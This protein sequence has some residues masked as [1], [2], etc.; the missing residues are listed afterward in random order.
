MPDRALKR[1]NHRRGID[2]SWRWCCKTSN[3][4]RGTET[5]GRSS[6]G[7]RTKL[8]KALLN[9]G[10]P[11]QSSVFECR[12]D[13]KGRAAMQKAIS[14]IGKPKRD[15]VRT[16]YLCKECVRR[17]EITSGTDVLGEPDSIVV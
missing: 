16:Y 5:V 8:H 17:T 2:P 1:R 10:T 9:Y 15:R 12:L 13:S 6:S 14:A 7:R 4:L 11:V 3:A